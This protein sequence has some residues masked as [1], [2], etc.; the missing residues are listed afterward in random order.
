MPV[1][2]RVNVYGT[3]CSRHTSA[4]AVEFHVGDII[5]VDIDEEY[6][7][8]HWW[9]STEYIPIAL[10]DNL[11]VKGGLV[12][13]EYLLSKPSEAYDFWW[14]RKVVGAK[15]VKRKVNRTLSWKECGF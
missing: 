15:C 11:P 12:E 5:W 6:Q 9:A 2:R 3:V 10:F 1:T 7:G 8:E 14:Y 4:N 13:V